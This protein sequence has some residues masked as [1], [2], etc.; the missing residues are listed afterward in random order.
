MNEQS[1]D[2]ILNSGLSEPKNFSSN[3]LFKKISNVFKLAGKGVIEKVFLLYAVFKD[4]N[5][6]GHIKLTIASGLS[7]FI[8]PFDAIPDFLVGIGFTDDLTVLMGIIYLLNS[9]I[10]QEQKSKANE[11]TA[12]Y[13]A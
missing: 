6:P 8:L 10:T 3:T 7:Y 5:V 2:K 11:W 9:T 12:K 1:Q 13:F 4:E